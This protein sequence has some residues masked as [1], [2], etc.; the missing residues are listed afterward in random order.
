VTP[1]LRSELAPSGRLRVGINFGNAVLASRDANGRPGGVAVYLA[2]ELA[3]RVGTPL[4]IVPFE[5]AG[6]MADGA[7]AGAWDVAFLGADPDRAAEIAFSAPYLEIDTTYLVPTASPLRT[8][9]DVDRE[10]VRVAVSAKG[11]YDLFLT[12]ELKRARLVRAPSSPESIDLFFKE[13]LEA[14]AGLRPV[15][16]DLVEQRPGYRV[17]DGRF[18]VV[19]QAVGT[20]KRRTAAAR[21]LQ[22]FVEDIK[23]SGLAASRVRRSRPGSSDL[24]RGTAR[25]QSGSRPRLIRARMPTPSRTSRTSSTPSP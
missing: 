19:Y 8:I 10:G 4:D 13:R 20:P 5:S 9:Q 14:L 25:R 24:N 12:R 23:D 2:Q 3:R 7:A 6:R 18:T 16:V 15:L 17:L 22:E 11:A 21:F 1:A